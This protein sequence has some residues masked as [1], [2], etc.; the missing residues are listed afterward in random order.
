MLVRAI[1]KLRRAKGRRSIDIQGRHPAIGWILP[2]KAVGMLMKWI[3][4]AKAAGTQES[5]PAL[6]ILAKAMC[7]LMSL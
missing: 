7:S 2:A 5:H 3:L 4:P 6:T 1:E